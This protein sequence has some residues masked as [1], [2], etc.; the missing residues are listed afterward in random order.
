MET[1]MEIA[2]GIIYGLGIATIIG[3]LA[4]L[5]IKIKLGGKI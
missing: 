2:E 5:A 4:K 3:I 1:A